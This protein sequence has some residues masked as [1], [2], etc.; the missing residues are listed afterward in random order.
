MGGVSWSW[1]EVIFSLCDSQPLQPEGGLQMGA[2][3]PSLWINGV[4]VTSCFIVNVTAQPHLKPPS[5]LIDFISTLCLR[6]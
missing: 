2:N 6:L 3:Q 5:S 1:I 4:S